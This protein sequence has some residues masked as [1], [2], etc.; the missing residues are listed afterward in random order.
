LR[1]RRARDEREADGS[2]SAG[3]APHGALQTFMLLQPGEGGG[4]SVSTLHG[5]E[6]CGPFA[7]NGKQSIVSHCALSLHGD[8][9]PRSPESPAASVAASLEA[10]TGGLQLHA[11]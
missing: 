7:L 4:Q 11:P 6:Q 8:M 2:E 3:E 10:S 1:E 5:F 9:K